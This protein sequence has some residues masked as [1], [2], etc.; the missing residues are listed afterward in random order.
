MDADLF[1]FQREMPHATLAL[2][3]ELRAEGYVIHKEW[4][5]GIEMRKGKPLRVWLLVFHI[6]LVTVL[7]AFLLPL[8]IRSIGNN[9]WGYKHRRLVTID[10]DG[11]D[12]LL[13]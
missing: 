12:C 4:T 13:V 5:N 1:Q 9:L 3:A 8:F 2:V 11:A 10:Q 7:P 6:L